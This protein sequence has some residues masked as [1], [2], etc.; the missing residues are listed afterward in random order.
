[1]YRM[2]DRDREREGERGIDREKEGDRE[3]GIE[4]ERQR[5]RKRER[6][7]VQLEVALAWRAVYL[8]GRSAPQRWQW[9]NGQDDAVP[10]WFTGN[11]QL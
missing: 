2:S 10:N 4:R 11:T 3:R 7:S 5:E 9:A 1:M 8:R 6:G